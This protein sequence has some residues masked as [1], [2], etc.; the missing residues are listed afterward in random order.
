MSSSNFKYV[1]NE[2][3]LPGSL[4]DETSNNY[5]NENLH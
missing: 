2:S 5:N 1:N 4:R 3:E